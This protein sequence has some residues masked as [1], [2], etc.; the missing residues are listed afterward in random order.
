[1]LRAGRAR[2]SLT[3]SC[4]SSPLNGKR[5]GPVCASLSFIARNNRP[6]FCNGVPSFPFLAGVLFFPLAY[7]VHLFPPAPTRYNRKSVLYRYQWFFQE[8]KYEIGRA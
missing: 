8:Q 6:P 5:I 4:A 1:M 3:T 7:P 2:R